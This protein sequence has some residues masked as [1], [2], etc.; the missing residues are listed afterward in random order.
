MKPSDITAAANA[1]KDAVNGDVVDDKEINRRVTI[2]K[3]C[4]QRRK[5]NGF[6]SRIS[7]L[8]GDLANRHRVPRDIADY[9][10]GVCGCSLLL[11]TPATEKDLHKD[12]PEEAKKRPR[13]CWL[14]KP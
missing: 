5:V 9:K 13:Q 12:S 7:K 3:A 1:F 8:L 4:P 11:L 6:V 14:P 10:C 2:C